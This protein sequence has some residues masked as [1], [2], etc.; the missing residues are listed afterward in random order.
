MIDSRGRP[1]SPCGLTYPLLKLSEIVSFLSDLRINVSIEDLT[2]PTASKMVA[3][4]D[5]FFEILMGTSQSQ[6]SLSEEGGESVA[7]SAHPELHVESEKLIMHYIQLYVATLARLQLFHNFLKLIAFNMCP[8]LMRGE[9]CFFFSRRNFMAGLGFNDFSL[10]DVLKPDPQRVVKCLSAAIN[11]TKF[12]EQRVT[13]LEVV[14][15][16]AVSF[17]GNSAKCSFFL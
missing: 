16:K 2:K 6:L 13:A 11:F 14:T 1:N 17:R 15:E 4:Y 8:I 5:D 12:R 7:Y 9:I 10:A 3:I